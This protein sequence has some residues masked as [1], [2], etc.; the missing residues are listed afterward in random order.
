MECLPS[1]LL[2]TPKTR[3]QEMELDLYILNNLCLCVLIFNKGFRVTV[4]V[5]V[6]VIVLCMQVIWQ[7]GD[8]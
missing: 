4:T 3:L 2:K 8:S 7:L 5:K 1:R 6:V